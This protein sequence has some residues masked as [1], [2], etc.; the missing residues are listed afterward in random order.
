[1]HVGATMALTVDIP[2]DMI[3]KL[4]VVAAVLFSVEIG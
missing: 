1:M 2:T 4:L 3:T